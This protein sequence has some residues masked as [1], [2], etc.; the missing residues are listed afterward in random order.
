ME[1]DVFA[2][3]K[4]GERFVYDNETFVKTENCDRYGIA[5]SLREGRKHK[6]WAFRADAKVRRFYT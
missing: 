2:D 3:V 1:A 5:W 4:V 6:E